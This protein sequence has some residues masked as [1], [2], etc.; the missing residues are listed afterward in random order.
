MANLQGGACKNP[1]LMTSVGEW[2]ERRKLKSGYGEII[3]DGRMYASVYN[4]KRLQLFV[5][6]WLLEREVGGL[7]LVLITIAAPVRQHCRISPQ[8]FRVQ[9]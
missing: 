2:Y 3:M 6:Y 4:R 1:A 5:G 9:G 7:C 8:D